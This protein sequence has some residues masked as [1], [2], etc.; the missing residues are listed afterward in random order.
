MPSVEQEPITY[1]RTDARFFRRA[2]TPPVST[3]QQENCVGGPCPLA[4]VYTDCWYSGREAG[5]AS[6]FKPVV[7]EAVQTLGTLAVVPSYAL[8]ICALPAFSFPYGWRALLHCLLAFV[9]ICSTT[10]VT[11]LLRRVRRTTACWRGVSAVC[12]EPAGEPG[13]AAAPI[14]GAA[15]QQSSAT[16][17]KICLRIFENLVLLWFRQLDLFRG[18]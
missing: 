9:H 1:P 8:T 11:Q 15:A 7:M 3:S 10:R 5:T 2:R 18:G 6:S 14:P 17:C 13:N 16:I 12:L 4:L